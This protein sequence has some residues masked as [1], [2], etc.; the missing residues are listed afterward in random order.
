MK[1][2]IGN[3]I[4]NDLPT[5][6]NRNYVGSL[7]IEF[8]FLKKLIETLERPLISIPNNSENASNPF[9]AYNFILSITL[10]KIF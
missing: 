5:T 1:K 4:K 6:Y 9:F 3:L 2:E 7:V 10:F 8:N